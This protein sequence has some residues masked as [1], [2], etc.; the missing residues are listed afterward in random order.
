MHQFLCTQ[1]PYFLTKISFCFKKYSSFI[2]IER[3]REKEKEK[4]KERERETDRQT[5]TD[6]DTETPSIV[7][8]L[9]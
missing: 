4:E 3:E 9:K 8:Q 5:E 7:S 2:E 6:T 1:K